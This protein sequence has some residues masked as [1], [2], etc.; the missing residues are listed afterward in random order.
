MNKTITAS[1][2]ICCYSLKRFSDIIEAIKSVNSQTKKPHEI[3]I[4]VDHNPELLSALKTQLPSDIKLFL[5]EGAPGLSETRNVGII[6]ASGQIIAFLD[7]DAIAKSNWLEKLILPFEDPKVMVIG[8]KTLPQWP[9][10]SPPFWF[11][12]ELYWIIGCT[13]KG[14]ALRGNKIRNVLGANMAFRKSVFEKIGFFRSEIGRSGTSTGCGEEADICFRISG[15]MPE[16]RILYEA[17]AVIDHK[18]SL[19]R[20]TWN[21]LI[22]R[23][24]N[25]GMYK[26]IIKRLSSGRFKD[27]LST[28]GSYLRYLLFKSI[29][30]KLMHFWNYKNIP[31]VIAVLVCIIATAFGYLLGR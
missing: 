9:K 20:L 3:I 29:P 15:A 1:V 31:Q 28:E 14:F 7:D 4:V 17:Q 21:Y 11:P 5:N 26:R 19:Q 27:V 24:F 16:A 22:Q 8:G 12:E 2:I 18:A 30:E 10:S 23:S 13:Y 6:N 25:E